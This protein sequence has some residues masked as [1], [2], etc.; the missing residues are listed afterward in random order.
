MK[1]VLGNFVEFSFYIHSP[2]HAK[3]GVSLQKSGVL[4][5]TVLYPFDWPRIKNS[6]FF[7][8]LKIIFSQ[9]NYNR[10]FSVLLNSSPILYPFDWKIIKKGIFFGSLKIIFS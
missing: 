1:V 5:G 8:Y 9:F 4:G 2:L 10:S 3:I 7:W 6:M